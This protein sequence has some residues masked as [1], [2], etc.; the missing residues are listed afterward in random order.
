MY[1]PQLGVKFSD[2]AW[3]EFLRYADGL[4]NQQM[5]ERAEEYFRQWEGNKV[6][7]RSIGDDAG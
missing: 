7:S 5:F 2:E 3:K 6:I 1:L 4:D